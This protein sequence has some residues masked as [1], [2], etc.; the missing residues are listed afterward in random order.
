M[1]TT[2]GT[3]SGKKKNDRRG[4]CDNAHIT[5][6]EEQVELKVYS[7]DTGIQGRRRRRSG[8]RPA[9]VFTVKP[10]SAGMCKGSNYKEG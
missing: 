4:G 9:K 7:N 10:V 1:S 8:Q 6:D 5:K 3:G 2:P